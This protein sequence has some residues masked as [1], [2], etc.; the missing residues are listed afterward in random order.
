MVR[1]QARTNAVL[2]GVLILSSCGD[3]YTKNQDQGSQPKSAQSDAD[4]NGKSDTGTKDDGTSG[5]ESQSGS[6]DNTTGSSQND[7]GVTIADILAGIFGNGTSSGNDNTNNTGSGQT[8]NTT[9]VQPAPEPTADDCIGADEFICAVEVAIT[10]HTN[11]LRTGSDLMHHARLSYVAR[12]WS[13]QQ[14]Q[15]GSIGHQGFPSSRSSFYKASFPGDTVSIQAENVAYSSGGST[16]TAE[17][18]AKM[19]VNMWKNSAGHRRNMLGNYQI[20]GVGVTKS[21]N[22]YYATQ[23]FGAE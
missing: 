6:A 23:I 11:L 4:A 3:D 18:V 9:P 21:G 16:A 2:A 15:R 1:R 7:A 19:F 20:L 8:S 10:Y 12:D 22:R 17:D 14:M 13:R 5:D